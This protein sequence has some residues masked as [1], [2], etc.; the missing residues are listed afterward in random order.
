MIKRLAL[1][2]SVAVFVAAPIASASADCFS[3]HATTASTPSAPMTVA[4]GP[5]TTAPAQ[6]AG[7]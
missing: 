6:P 5:S 3:G 1:T 4:E 2:L 7:N